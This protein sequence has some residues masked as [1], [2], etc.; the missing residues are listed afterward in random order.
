[1]LLPFQRLPTYTAVKMDRKVVLYLAIFL[2]TLAFSEVKTENFENKLAR[3]AFRACSKLADK[4]VEL[5]QPVHNGLTR[6][7]EVN[8]ICLGQVQQNGTV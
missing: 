6:L 5:N 3:K 7:L 2:A 1:M 4:V 8:A